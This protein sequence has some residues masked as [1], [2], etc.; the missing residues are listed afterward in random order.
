[1]FVNHTGIVTKQR[2]PLRQFFEIDYILIRGNGQGVLKNLISIYERAFFAKVIN[3]FQPL[4]LL[5]KKLHHRYLI[6]SEI[7]A[8]LLCKKCLFRIINNI[9]DHSFIHSFSTNVK[10]SGKTNISYSLIRT[11]TFLCQGVRNRIFSENFECLLNGYSLSEVI[12]F[13][14]FRFLIIFVLCKWE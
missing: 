5:Q 4:T 10:F 3:G 8:W 14:L 2:E 7:R 1:M 11:R 6:W 13:T 12:I 9:R